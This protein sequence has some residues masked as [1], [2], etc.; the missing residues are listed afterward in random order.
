MKILLVGGAKVNNAAK[1]LMQRFNTIETSVASRPDEIELLGHSGMRYDRIIVFEQS[2]TRDGMD[3]DKKAIRERTQ[4]VITAIKE[5]FDAFDLVGVADSTEVLQSLREEMFE[6][7]HK[8]VVVKVRANSLSANILA[9]LV[10]KSI[11]ELRELYKE[12]DV[13]RSIYKSASSVLWSSEVE[14]SDDWDIDDIAS[15]NGEEAGGRT[16]LRF[17]YG[18]MEWEEVGSSADN[19]SNKDN[20]AGQARSAEQPKADRATTNKKR[21]GLFGNRKA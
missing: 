17:N 8:A 14:K 11:A 19:N 21:F 9:G 5:A 10:S 16:K 18:T 2:L 15:F 1:A 13:D 12:V 6:I 3:I 4:R 20:V 7:K